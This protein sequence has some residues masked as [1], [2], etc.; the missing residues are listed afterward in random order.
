MRYAG[1]SFELSVPVPME[2]SAIGEIEQAFGRVYAARYGAAREAATE[3][4]SYRLA[5]WGL[6]EKPQLPV[7]DPAGRT[8]EAA[9]SGERAVVF[10]AREQQVPIFDRDRLPPGAEV[11]GPALIEEGGS[12]TVVPPGWNAALDTLGCLVLRRS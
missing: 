3:I 9:R 8:L 12:T 1:Q 5:A 2:V 4:V 10:G 6:T 11:T 7:I